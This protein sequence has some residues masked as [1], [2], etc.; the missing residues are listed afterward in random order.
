MNIFGKKIPDRTYLPRPG[1]YGALQN[2]L[3]QLLIVENGGMVYLPGGGIRL[4]EAF[5]K[6]LKREFL[7]ETGFVISVGEQFAEAKQ[8]V[9]APDEPYGYVKHCKFFHV[10]TVER[11]SPTEAGNRVLWLD[12]GDALAELHEAAHR[13]ALSA[14]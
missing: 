2:A 10:E 4:G 12:R 9:H 13:W 1:A 5:D 8:I 11:G 14:L 3:S 6:C 7:E